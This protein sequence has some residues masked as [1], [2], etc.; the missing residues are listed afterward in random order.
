M[1]NLHQPEWEVNKF[2]LAGTLGVK[3]GNLVDG[4][5]AKEVVKRS[6]TLKSPEHD[7]K[8]LGVKMSM[9]IYESFPCIHSWER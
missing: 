6:Q 1:L 7:S 3:H 5:E 2:R 8:K 9:S 4:D